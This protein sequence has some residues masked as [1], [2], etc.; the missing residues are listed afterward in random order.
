MYL[1]NWVIGSHMFSYWVKTQG[2]K[3]NPTHQAQIFNVEEEMSNLVSS[4]IVFSFK[5][6]LFKA[7]KSTYI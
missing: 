7:A 5:K 3:I 2:L 6:N 1:Y 4:K